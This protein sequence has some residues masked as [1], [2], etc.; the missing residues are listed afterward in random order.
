MLTLKEV[1][2]YQLFMGFF[3]AIIAFLQAYNHWGERMVLSYTLLIG[4]SLLVMINLVVLYR[5]DKKSG[6]LEKERSLR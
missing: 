3:V 1:P 5:K 2:K 4:G 6:K